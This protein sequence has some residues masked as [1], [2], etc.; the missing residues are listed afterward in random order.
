MKKLLIVTAIVEALTGL[1]CSHILQSPS[2]YC[3]AEITRMSVLI[4]RLTGIALIALAVACWPDLN[5]FRA[6][7][8]MLTYNVLA[9]LFLV[10]AGLIGAS[11][12]LLWPAVALHAGR[13]S[14]LFKP[15]GGNDELRTNL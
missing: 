1:T 12:I 2:G 13:P 14:F 9:T 6:L 7:F 8:G 3:S 4:S 10:Y 15:G 5:L 11:G